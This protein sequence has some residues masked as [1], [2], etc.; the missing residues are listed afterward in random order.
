MYVISEEKFKKVIESFGL[1]ARE[2]YN[3]IECNYYDDKE[4]AD[5]DFVCR[6]VYVRKGY[7]E[8]ECANEIN[9]WTC[10]KQ[11]RC[12]GFRAVYTI[13]DFIAH[14]R[15]LRGDYNKAKEQMKKDMLNGMFI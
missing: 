11:I 4:I 7:L 6:G 2:Y 8:V 12:N 5:M 15:K 13:E 14:L 3:C 9:K 1:Q 10:D